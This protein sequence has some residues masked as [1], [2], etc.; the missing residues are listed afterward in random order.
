MHIDEDKLLAWVLD[1]LDSEDEKREIAIHLERC[2]ECRSRLEKLK[3][4]IEIIGDIRPTRG[5]A[6]PAQKSSRPRLVYS[7]IRAAVLV[8][9]GIGVGF[10]ISAW[11]DDT[12][13]PVSGFYADLSPAPDSV[14][15]YAPSDATGVAV[16]LE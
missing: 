11:L 15:R 1:T 5:I 6:N 12:P 10:G 4:D 7:F 2:V 3:S 14:S 16:D 13:A 8:L 9:F